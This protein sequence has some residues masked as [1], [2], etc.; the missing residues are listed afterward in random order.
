MA[1]LARTTALATVMMATSS[2]A[3][4]ETIT[5]VTVNNSDM[6]IMQKLSSQWEEATGNE[7]EW[8]V[9]EENVLRQR[10]TTDIATGGGQ[11]DVITIGS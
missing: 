4:A 5:I 1:N 7:I 8:L 3:M 2:L 6:I 10:V 11:F 9:L